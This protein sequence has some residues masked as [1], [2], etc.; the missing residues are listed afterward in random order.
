MH[1]LSPPF[2]TSHPLT[3]QML[4]TTVKRS[5]A[6]AVAALLPTGDPRAD[7]A[8]LTLAAA[9]TAGFFL[10]TSPYFYPGGG[11]HFT[12]WAE[13]LFHGTKLNPHFAQRDVGFPLL[14]LLSGYIVNGSFI[15][16][17]LIHAAFAILMPI[18][19]YLAIYRLSQPVA[20]LTAA[21]AIVSF[22]PVYFMKWIHHDQTYIFFTVLTAALLAIYLQTHRLRYLYFFTAA[23]LA[24]SLS[25]P[26]GNILFP[27]FLALAYVTVRGRL[28][29]YV[30]CAGIFCAVT[31][32]YLWHRHEIFDMAHR[33][34]IPSYTGQQVFYNIYINAAEFGVR[35]SPGLGPNLTILGNCLH[36]AVQPS[37]R[38]APWVKAVA[39]SASK[40]FMEEYFYRYTPDELKRRAF[41]APNR[42]YY[43]FFCAPQDNDQIFLKASLEVLRAYPWYFFAYTGRN[44]WH[45]LARPGFSHSRYDAIPFHPVG[46]NFPA[47]RWEEN[48]TD[49]LV[50]IK[51]RAAREVIFEPLS[52][53]PNF[54]VKRFHN[55]EKL[56][57]LSY[58]TMVVVT[59]ALMVAAWLG[60]LVR[61]TLPFRPTSP[62]VVTL[63]EIFVRDGLAASI[64]AVSLL[65]LYNFAV[66]AAFVE[67]D[68][69]YH[70]FMVLL[71][72]LI[73]G[74][75]LIVLSR[76]LNLRLAGT[77]L[78]RIVAK[79]L[80]A[81][82][83]EDA[84]A[85][86]VSSHPRASTF[87]IGM[88]TLALFAGWARFMAVHTW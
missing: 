63:A 39:Q 87:A 66:T 17:T 38:E 70:H 58:Q 5:V 14:I 20:F 44:L 23:A 32:G 53:A 11:D 1:A 36:E 29:H 81:L 34:N 12:S 64:I 74:Y 83:R 79:G 72:V 10:F 57:E 4:L 33:P 27:I 24:A 85:G 6:T 28:F 42:E 86:V 69:R 60:V 15:G 78:V 61:F 48:W 77:K 47:G 65:L 8:K 88:V 35:L 54:V 25:R 52:I 7:I 75:G 19:L 68:Y 18:L 21:F 56:W 50:H 41:E 13:A 43:Q 49:G 51:A 37:V 67:P 84:F 30:V 80:A 62:R 82:R 31:A 2:G 76:L 71:R 40:E 22:A 3:P 45:L 55:I 9:V 46:N 16:I 26:A 59:L 73:A